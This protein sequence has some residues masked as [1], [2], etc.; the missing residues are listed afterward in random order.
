LERINLSSIKKESVK[1]IFGAITGKD[2]I[3]RAEIAEI[4]GLSLMTVGKVVDAFLERKVVI[5]SK[6]VKNAAGRRAGLVRLN[7]DKFFLILDVTSKNMSMVV[8]D[9]ALNIVDRISYE[10]NPEFYYDENLYIF[11]KNV[12][13]YTLRNLKM[14]NSIGIGVVLPGNYV[15]E[16]DIIDETRIPEQAS[17]HIKSIIEN[18]LRYPVDALEKDVLMAAAS[19]LADLRQEELRSVVYVGIGETIS[20]VLLCDGRILNGRNAYAGDIGKMMTDSG[21][22]LCDLFAERGLREDTLYAI[23][24]AIAYEILLLDPNIVLI[25][26]CTDQKLG[27]FREILEKRVCSLCGITADKLPDIRLLETGIRHAYRGIAIHMRSEWI[28]KTTE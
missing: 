8:M 9:I 11:M 5:Q 2:H 28:E 14:E 19:N 23:T 25:E 16:K 18:V 3:S 1:A 17:T 10:Y 21:R 26:N 12:K 7:T 20:G 24:T 13:I 15:P 22:S 6:E 27:R 4:T